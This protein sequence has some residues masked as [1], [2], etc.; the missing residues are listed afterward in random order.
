MSPPSPLQD[1]WKEILSLLPQGWEDQAKTLGAL[2]R[3]RGI[4][5]AEVLLRVLLIHLGTDKSLR[6]TVAFA[7]AAGLCSV[8]DTTL[9]ERLKGSGPWL[10]WLCQNL[11][12]DGGLAPAWTR[13][14]APL[15]PIRL[16]DGTSISEKGSTG[17]DWRVHFTLNLAT[18]SCDFFKVTPN[19]EGE[20]LTLIPIKQ[21]DILVADRNFASGKEMKWV[22]DSGGDVLVRYHSGMLPLW[23]PTGEP[24]PFLKHFPPLPT[25]LPAEFPAK[26]IP[27]KSQEP[28][29]VR[30]LV[31]RKTVEQGEKALAE[32]RREAKKKKVKIQEKTE[33]LAHFVVLVTTLPVQEFALH[34]CL[35]LY[36]CRWQ[37]E[38]EFKQ[39]KQLM[40]LGH[41]PKY[42]PT[43]CKAWIQ[44]KL[45]LA[46]LTDRLHLEA[47]RFSPWGYGLPGL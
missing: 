39:M 31:L 30:I 24:F 35:D 22:Q 28:L 16:V 10:T 17:S 12:K 43:S 15:R 20:S 4:P 37:I 3:K 18:L 42:D 32:A 47:E 40:G 9:L 8:A 19:K 26:V 5:S 14:H 25:G 45:L 33:L 29:P 27:P 7:K 21:G 11:L 2:E 44:G 34:Q 38:L 36:R 46:L 6:T 1:N 41:L 23:T 13:F